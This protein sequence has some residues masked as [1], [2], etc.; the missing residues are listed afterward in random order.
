MTH[1]SDY[2]SRKAKKVEIK[3]NEA[4]M[5]L[6]YSDKTSL[7]SRNFF[8]RFLENSL[9]ALQTCSRYL[10]GAPSYVSHAPGR[11]GAPRIWGMPRCLRVPRGTGACPGF[12]GSFATPTHKVTIE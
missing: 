9:W 3:K 5:R 1:Q 8:Q 6:E 10:K 11:S 2:M 4:E 12:L 7:L